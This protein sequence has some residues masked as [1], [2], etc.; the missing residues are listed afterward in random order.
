MENQAIAYFRQGWKSQ[1]HLSEE[2]Q[3]QKSSGENMIK[4]L[5]CDF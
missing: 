2:I 5:D 3:T 1:V 4:Y